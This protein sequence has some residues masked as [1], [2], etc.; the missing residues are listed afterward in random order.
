MGN[1]A[2]GLA[3]HSGLCLSIMFC[4]VPL[5]SDWF[6][7]YFLFFRG[8]RVRDMIQVPTD[9]EPGKYVL[10]FRWDCQLTPQIWNICANVDIF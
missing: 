6:Q 10:S 8:G 7:L 5:R 3:E 9:L 1:T 4:S 2:M